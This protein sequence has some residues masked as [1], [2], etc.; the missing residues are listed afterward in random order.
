MTT[1]TAAPS[2][3][4]RIID[5]NRGLLPAAKRREPQAVLA[6]R[7]AARRQAKDFAAALQG[8]TI[9]VIAEVKSASPSAGVIAARVDPVAQAK[10]YAKAGAAA[11]SVLTERKHF[12]GSLRRLGAISSAFE[13]APNAQ[14]LPPLLRKDFLFDPYQVYQ[15]RAY[16][17]DTFLLIV[18]VLETPLLADLL[19]LG[20]T[21][22]MEALVEVHDEGEVDRALQ[23]GARVIGINNRDLNTFTVSLETTGRVAQRIPEECVVVSE[24]GIKTQADVHQLRGWGADAILVGETLMTAPSLNDKMRELMS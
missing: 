13:A 6:E 22:G 14:N 2:I 19:Q 3:L 10:R 11:I 23:S 9:R 15:A 8:D 16:G 1:A 18:A 20:R 12:R 21:L 24:S 5:Y 7:A 17:A 4:R